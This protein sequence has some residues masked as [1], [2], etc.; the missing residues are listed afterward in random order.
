MRNAEKIPLMFIS[1]SQRAGS[2]SAPDADADLVF[3]VRSGE[4]DAFEE[5]FHRHGRRVY[6]TLVGL[7]GNPEDAEDGTQNAFWKAF[8]H[9]GEFQGESKFSTWLT[10]IAINEGLECLR[11]RR[12]MES[13]DADDHDGEEGARPRQVKDLKDN[14]EE[15]CLRKQTSE[16]V[17]REVGKLPAKYR[18]VVMLRDIEELS[19]EEAA[20]TLGLGMA[21]LK[22]RLLRGRLALRRALTPHFE[23][24]LAA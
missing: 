16:I 6:R 4:V 17:R 10:R 24:Q 13:L 11:K 22:T 1:G 20:V 7:T 21:A 19:T 2:G 9:I 15:L 23:E 5:L 14:P 3:R 18:S 8:Q 12:D